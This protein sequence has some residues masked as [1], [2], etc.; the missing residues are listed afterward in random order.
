VDLPAVPFMLN[1][2]DCLGFCPADRIQRPAD[3]FVQDISHP[4]QPSS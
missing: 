3:F 2:I 4:P 1:R